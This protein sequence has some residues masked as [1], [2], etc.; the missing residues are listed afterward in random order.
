MGFS[1]AINKLSL[2]SKLKFLESVD[3]MIKLL[4]LMPKSQVSK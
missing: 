3:K 2:I 1:R 4:K